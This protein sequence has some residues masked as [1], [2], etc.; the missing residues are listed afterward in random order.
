MDTRSIKELRNLGTAC[1]KD[2]HFVEIYTAQD[3]KQL[4]VEGTFIKLMEGR[5]ARGDEGFSFNATYLYALYGAIHDCDWR[6]VPEEKK[7]EFKKL[8]ASLRKKYPIRKPKR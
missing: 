5:I 6:E 4:G 8:T 3:I 7:R 1:E 2:L